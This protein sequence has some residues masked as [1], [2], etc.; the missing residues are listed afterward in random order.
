MRSV[1]VGSGIEEIIIGL[2]ERLRRQL[3]TKTHL[4]HTRHQ[5]FFRVVKNV[6]DTTKV[7]EMTKMTARL[8]L[9]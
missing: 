1:A 9:P 3:T 5:R 2:Q 8:S 4:W 6:T 7:M